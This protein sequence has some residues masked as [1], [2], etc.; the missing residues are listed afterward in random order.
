[1]RISGYIC[2]HIDLKNNH[3][4][5]VLYMYTCICIINIIFDC[6]QLVLIKLHQ[7]SVFNIGTN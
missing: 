4:E 7:S 2:T 6:L 3:N 1:M 5:Y